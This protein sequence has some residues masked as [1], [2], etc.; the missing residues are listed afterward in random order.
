MVMAVSALANDGQMMM[1]HLLRSMVDN[2]RQYTP[3]RTMIGTPISAETRWRIYWLKLL[4]E[5]SSDALVT[6][7]RWQARPALPKSRP[8]RDTNDV[9]HASFV[10]W[11][12]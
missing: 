7:Y 8:R 4:E 12:R 3:A 6:G 11:G 2:N 5:E 9:T 10:G 1:P